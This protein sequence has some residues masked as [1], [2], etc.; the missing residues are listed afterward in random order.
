[1][2]TI[3]INEDNIGL[4]PGTPVYVGDRP[5]SAMGISVLTYSA[6]SA[7]E[8]KIYSINELSLLKSDGIMWININGLKDIDAIKK[9]AQMY[10]IHSLTIEDIL[11]TKQQPKVEIFEN[12]RFISFKSIQEKN[13]EKQ[14]DGKK[15]KKD[16]DPEDFI[17]E[18][19]S[20]IVME[21]TLITFQEITG[22]SFNSIRKRI[23]ENI[24]RICSRGTDYLAYSLIDAVVDEYYITLAGIEED[25]EDLEDRAIKTS[26]DNFIAEIQDTKKYLFQIKRAML[27]LREN[28]IIIS[29]QVLPFTK[30]D[31]KPFLQDLQENLNNAIETV[32]NYREW[33][34]N[35]MD[36]NLSVLTYQMNKVM[37][38]LAIVSAIFIPLTFIAGVYG[39]NFENMPE[40]TKPW[41]YPL[42]LTA[43][44]LTALGM[45][46]FFKVR[47]WF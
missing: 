30:S 26:N 35:I 4:P 20:M 46:I 36:V 37:K 29:H 33:L 28:L 23:L 18:Q 39:M 3:I 5:A 9:L 24:G 43:M 27:P 17:I 31:L 15:I 34:S 1:M 13:N 2:E 19:I 42:I 12:Y 45:V 11:N 40:L 6:S 32:E 16:D 21:N 7:Q 14:T 8:K 47:K 22:N 10:D 25:I 38:I 41:G 44:G